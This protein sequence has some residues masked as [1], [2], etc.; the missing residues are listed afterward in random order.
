MD[1]KQHPHH[2]SEAM[3]S[4]DH[5]DGGSQS[6]ST[7]AHKYSFFINRSS[8]HNDLFQQTHHCIR[9]RGQLDSLVHRSTS[10]GRR[11]PRTQGFYQ[12]DVAVS[13]RSGAECSIIASSTFRARVKEANT[14]MGILGGCAEYEKCVRD[15][16][17]SLGGR[18][19]VLGAEEGVTK[20]HRDL[21][22]ACS[23]AYPNECI[24]C[25]MADGITPG[26]K[27]DG[28][29]ACDGIDTTLIS[30]GSC[31]SPYACNGAQGPIGE[32]SCNSDGA[33]FNAA[34]PVEIHRATGPAL[35]PDKN[36][37]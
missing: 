9:H 28:E 10:S 22:S 32:S 27:C 20:A 5:L 16:S 33:C 21:A 8:H 36:V 24:T 3:K 1:I 12:G 30:C 37:S 15:A 13:S 26:K 18:C 19:I 4:T 25:K 31:N 11:G 14:D 34:G 29:N 7:M 23:G 17:S 6:S 35:V 2:I